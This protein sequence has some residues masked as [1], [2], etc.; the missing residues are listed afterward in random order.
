MKY[1]ITF[2]MSGGSKISSEID[3]EKNQIEVAEE[4]FHR[5]IFSIASN[6]PRTNPDLFIKTDNIDSLGILIVEDK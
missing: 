5:S 3:T 1:L 4:V 2:E 6:D